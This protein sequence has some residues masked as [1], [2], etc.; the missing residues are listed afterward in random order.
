MKLAVTVLIV[1]CALAVQAQTPGRPTNVFS[2][3]FNAIFRR[4]RPTAQQQAQAAAEAAAQNNP[5]AGVDLSQ[6]LNNQQQQ[7]P[8]VVTKTISVTETQVQT[9]TEILT[10]PN[11]ERITSVETIIE[12]TVQTVFET[13]T[14]KITEVMTDFMTITA[15]ACPTFVAKDEVSASPVV[16]SSSKAAASATT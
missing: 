7:A 8:E 1:C 2:A 11:I 6:I 9:E 16:K 14:I 10:V 5:L 3:I 15:T 12:Q 13:E 4:G